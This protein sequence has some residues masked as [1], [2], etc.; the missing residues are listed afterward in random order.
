MVEH[1]QRLGIFAA[2]KYN[3]STVELCIA[4]SKIPKLT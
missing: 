4:Q 3:S 2:M 1:C